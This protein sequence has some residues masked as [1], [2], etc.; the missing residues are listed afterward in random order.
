MWTYDSDS[1]E[2]DTFFWARGMPFGNGNCVQLWG[3]R[4]GNQTY[5][6]DDVRCCRE[7]KPLC[8]YRLEN[9]RGHR[10]KPFFK[11]AST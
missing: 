2:V 10:Q 5:M 3:L 8:Q 6:W 11:L 4:D 7:F 9:P 1:S